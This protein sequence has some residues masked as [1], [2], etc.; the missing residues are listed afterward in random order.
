MSAEENEQGHSFRE[1]LIYLS[2][3]LF[4]F[5]LIALLPSLS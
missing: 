4:V 2:V 5:N 3:S 1:Q